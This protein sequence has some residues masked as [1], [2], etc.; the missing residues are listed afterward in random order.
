MR[1]TSREYNVPHKKYD[2]GRE[3]AE[4]DEEEGKEETK[5]YYFLRKAAVVLAFGICK[6]CAR[7]NLSLT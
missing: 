6:P 3:E 1:D 2:E 7:F 5:L 4:G